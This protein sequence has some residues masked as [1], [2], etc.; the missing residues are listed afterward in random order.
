MEP[1]PHC[2]QS[3]DPQL[4]I[5][6]ASLLEL[7]N[8]LLTWERPSTRR[9]RK[10][11]VR[12]PHCANTYVSHTLRRFGFVTLGNYVYVVGLVC[13]AAVVIV[14]LLAPPRS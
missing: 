13:L 6:R 1:C 8:A 7:P 4:H 11:T 10:F 12:C 5:V 14:W 9:A 3:L 2:H